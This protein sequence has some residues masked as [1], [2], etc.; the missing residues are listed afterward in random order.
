MFKLINIFFSIIFLIFTALQWNDPDPY[1][2]MP[3]YLLSVGGCV[4]ALKDM[5]LPR[6]YF[7][8]IAI[9]VGYA[10]FLFL[11]DDGVWSWMMQH[12]FQSLTGSMKAGEPW[13]EN[14]REFGGLLIAI[15]VMCF[16]FVTLR[17]RERSKLLS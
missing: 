4:L 16:N 13:V 17:L 14:T 12:N 5:Y 1:L 7:A 2:W 11:T 6:F 8:T 9:Y 3:L 15:I 10:V